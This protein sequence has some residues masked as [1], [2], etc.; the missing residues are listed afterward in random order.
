MSTQRHSFTINASAAAGDTGPPIF[1][2]IEQV[3]W[4]PT[5]GD[6]GA[7]LYLALLHQQGDTAGGFTLLSKADCMGTGF[8]K[9]PT[10]PQTHVDLFDTG[11]SLDV[12]VVCAGDRLRLKVTPGN[13]VA[14]KLYVWTRN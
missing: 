13:T 1:G 2:S 11:A 14:G 3:R 6:T 7:D 12:P 10:I 9:Q 5:T 4:A 8:T